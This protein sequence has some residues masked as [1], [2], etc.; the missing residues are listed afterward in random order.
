LDSRCKNCSM[1]FPELQLHQQSD[2][3]DV[4]PCD[5]VLLLCRTLLTWNN[6]TSHLQ[7]HIWG[8]RLISNNIWY[9]NSCI[10][11]CMKTIIYD[12]EPFSFHIRV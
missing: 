2:K 8:C 4:S 12:V 6:W 11:L 10:S 5:E 1:C 9:Y 3:A 7:G